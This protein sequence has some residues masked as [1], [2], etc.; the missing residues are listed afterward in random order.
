MGRDADID[1]AMLDAAIL[2]AMDY[3]DWV[4]ADT[5]AQ[6]LKRRFRIDATT[7]GARLRSLKSRGLVRS[8]TAPAGYYSQWRRESA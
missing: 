6:S 3:H 2:V 7:V 5:I 4:T 1:K 8:Q